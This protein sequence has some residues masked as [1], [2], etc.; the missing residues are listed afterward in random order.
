MFCKEIEGERSKL[1]GHVAPLAPPPK[2]AGKSDSTSMALRCLGLRLH[3]GHDPGSYQQCVPT[4]CSNWVSGIS[5]LDVRSSCLAAPELVSRHH[6]GF[7]VAS[8]VDFCHTPLS[9]GLASIR[10]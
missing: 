5:C 8:E 6:A 3:F 7:S 9:V 10:C 1:L 2:A 4:V